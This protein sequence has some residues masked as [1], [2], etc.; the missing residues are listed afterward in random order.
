MTCKEPRVHLVSR[1][2]AVESRSN[3]FD[4]D[5][6][7]FLN[8]VM[9]GESFEDEDEEML[10]LLGGLELAGG[11]FSGEINSSNLVYF[12]IF[13]NSPSSYA[14]HQACLFLSRLSKVS[15]FI[16]IFKV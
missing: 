3:D 6:G 12:G 10:A 16:L 11:G 9:A 13:F 2:L 4:E 14:Y 15:L 8:A 7:E 5:G 1:P